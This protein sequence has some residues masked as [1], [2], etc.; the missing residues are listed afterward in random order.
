MV[1]VGARLPGLGTDP[2]P[3]VLARYPYQAA[4]ARPFYLT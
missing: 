2:D 1:T 3:A 4:S